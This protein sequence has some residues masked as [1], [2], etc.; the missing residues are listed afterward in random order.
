MRRILKTIVWA[1]LA[2][3]IAWYISGLAGRVSIE[4]GPY[5]VE[6]SDSVLV[7]A[8]LVLFA[9]LYILVRVVTL[10]V[11]VP[12]AGSLWRGARRRQAGERAVTRAL[13]ALAAGEK[14]D[15]RR[16]AAR[17]R[18][19]L[20]D[21]PQTL[22]LVAEAGR[23]SGRDDEAMAA[24]RALAAR[25]DSALL[26]LR[27]L[28]SSAIAKEKWPEAAALARQAEAAH[29]GAAWLRHERAQL[30]VRAGDWA[31]ALTL[32]GPGAGP[33]AGFGGGPRG[34]PRGGQGGGGGGPR[35]ALSVGAASQTALPDQA[36]R[37]TR[38]ALKADPG[39]VPAVLAH[40]TQS[41][42]RG[43]EKK[44]QAI[45]ADGWKRSP[46][47]DISAA[48]LAPSSDKNERLS[49]AKRLVAGAPDHP[50]SHLLLA[51]VS[52]DAGLV[53]EARR[54]LDAA[55]ASGL[56]QRRVWLLRAELEEE[57]HGDTE[58]GRMAQRDALRRAANADPDPEWR[59]ESCH[60][61]LPAWRPA[62]PAC[63]T[64]GA[65][66]WRA[67]SPRDVA[68]TAIVTGVVA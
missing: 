68:G 16:E 3:A 33:G 44:A 60:T 57:E 53:A 20:G 24:L 37:L 36:E 65:V 22:L 67:D 59:C 12:R 14:A 49:V 54:H 19:L 62:C 40:A 66:V 30:A 21:T 9:L 63:L 47:P 45:L 2:V 29:P 18:Q 51:R 8:L 15:A 25:K 23:L 56:D 1:V 7:A 46:H 55:Q 34:G 31:E 38:Q 52:L 26:G 10:V 32:V 27:G 6:T 50:E 41:R 28:L 13:V 58:A 11:L 39:F 48:A 42:A 17:A 5:T 43:R 4:A 61:A 64:P 35:A